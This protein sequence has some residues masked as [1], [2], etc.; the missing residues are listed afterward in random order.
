M[1]NCPKYPQPVKVLLSLV[2]AFFL[3]AAPARAAGDGYWHT[4][5]SQ[6]LDANN[7]PVKIAGVNWF[8][9]ETGSYA[10][11]GLWS[12]SYQDMINQIKSMGFNAIRLPFSNQALRDGS[13]PNGIDYAQN[14]DLAGL[15]PVQI[16]DKIIAYAGQSGLKVILDQHRPN[17]QSQSPLWYSSDLSENQWISDWQMLA[18]RYNGN[19]TVIGVDLHNEPHDN[20][21]WGSSDPATDWKLAATKAGNAILQIN[22]HLLVIVEG[23]QAYQNQWY[24]WG[25]NLSGVK[26]S[27]IQL[28]VP[29]QLVYSAHDYPASVSS[30]PWFN[31]PN[32]P[33]NLESLWDSTWGYIQKNNIAPVLLG[34]FGTKLETASDQQWYQTLISYLN[35]N[36]ISWTFWSLNPNS[37]DTGGLLLDDWQ[38][39]DNRKFDQLKP[40]MSPVSGNASVS[41]PVPTAAVPVATPAAPTPGSSDKTVSY[42]V[43]N[44]WNNGYLA[45][46]TVTNNSSQDLTNW[47]LTWDF[48]S[49]QQIIALW[50]GVFSQSGS[51]VTVRP[52]SWNQTIRPRETITIGFQGSYSGTNSTPSQFQISS[53]SAPASSAPVPTPTLATPAPASSPLSIDLWWPQPNSQVSGTQPLKAVVPG[54]GLS[55]YQI[56]W[57]VDGGQLNPLSDSQQDYPHKETAINF[58]GWNWHQSGPYQLT[59]IAKDNSGQLLA[60]KSFPLFI[61]P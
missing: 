10:P 19:P 35:K 40:L 8:G 7:T 58:T 30:Q 6:I 36:Q 41:S 57:Q 33:A 43:V 42:S 50:N 48:P 31:Q 38:T 32:Y 17:S 23:V 9:L 44:Q 37:G 1:T 61:D 26:D 55:Q 39:V 5:G 2:I 56:S 60:Q 54:L 16:M 11:H 46:L 4:Q 14:P 21:S 3:L 34:E 24:W 18:K 20:A 29:N 45:D 51:H 53:P 13:L 15:T 59:L 28:A 47:T 49:G 52:A 22:P 25:G 12:R 27:P